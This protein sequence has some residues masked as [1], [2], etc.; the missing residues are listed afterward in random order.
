MYLT[1]R[2]LP[3]TQLRPIGEDYSC[4]RRPTLRAPL[5][6]SAPCYALNCPFFFFFV[7]GAVSATWPQQKNMACS[8]SAF[9]VW[10]YSGTFVRV[11][12][13]I[14]SPVCNVPASCCHL[15]DSMNKTQ[16]VPFSF[17]IQSCTKLERLECKRLASEIL[18]W[19]TGASAVLY[20]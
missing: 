19:L 15:L 9:P 12:R 11:R 7:V 13:K 2:G 6:L 5:Q 1:E 18:V 10:G 20:Y 8:A 4:S 14:L 17:C 3:Y 16:R